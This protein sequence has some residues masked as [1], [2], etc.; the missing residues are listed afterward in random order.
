MG[1]KMTLSQ[2]M[3]LTHTSMML[4]KW[5][6]DTQREYVSQSNLQFHLQ[7]VITELPKAFANTRLFSCR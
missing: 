7:R 1:N 3:T 2:L 4:T 6:L 5:L